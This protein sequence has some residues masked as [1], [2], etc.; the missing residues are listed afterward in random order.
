MSDQQ[1]YQMLMTINTSLMQ[2]LTL[3]RKMQ[4]EGMKVITQESHRP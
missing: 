3:L 2:I 1:N 4:K